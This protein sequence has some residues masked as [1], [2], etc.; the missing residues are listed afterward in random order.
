MQEEDDDYSRKMKAVCVNCG[1]GYGYHYSSFGKREVITCE[2]MHGRIE[3][4]RGTYYSKQLDEVQLQRE[5]ERTL[6]Q[7]RHEL[8]HR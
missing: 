4:Y 7:I 5:I 6:F 2:P 8:L 3:Q 1:R